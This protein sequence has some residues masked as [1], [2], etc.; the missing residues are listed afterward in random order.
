MTEARNVGNHT[1]F[2]FCPYDGSELSAPSNQEA[3]PGHVCKE[4]GFVDYGNPKPCVAVLVVRGDCVLLARRGVEPAKAKWDIL[5]G[6][7]DAGEAVEEAVRREVLEESGLH[8]ESMQYVGSFAD[9]YAEHAT[10]TIPT[11]NVCFIAPSN[12][13]A[14]RPASDV[15]E[16]RWFTR[17]EAPLEDLAFAHQKELLARW[18]G[19]DY[20]WCSFPPAG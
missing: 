10:R 6:F 12:D 9:V 20:A 5:G 4:C 11:L 15:A 14:E 13:G 8:L 2:R 18:A 1:R 7:V 16:L 19:G 3:P 17:E